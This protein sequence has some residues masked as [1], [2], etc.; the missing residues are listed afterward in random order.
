M[1]NT[2]NAQY[3]QEVHDALERCQFVEETIRVYVSLAIK[4][5]KLSLESHFPLQFTTKD[6]SKLSLGKLV[7]IFSRLSDDTSLISSLRKLTT[8][9]NHVAHKSRLFTLGELQDPVH[10]SEATQKITEIR[11][12]AK[13]AH[14]S[15]LDK[16]YELRKSLHALRRCKRSIDTA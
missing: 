7:N 6:L 13:A 14:E 4:I 10:M 5:A 8:G 2:A 11:D 16:T 12:S 15:L 9:R 3:Q 1:G